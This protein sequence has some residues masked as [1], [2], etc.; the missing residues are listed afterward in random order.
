LKVFL[1]YSYNPENE[2]LAEDLLAV[3][4]EALGFTP[5]YAKKKQQ[6]SKP[7]G[8]RNKEL[9]GECQILVGLLTKDVHETKDGKDI[10]HPESDV[11]DEVSYADGRGLKVIVLVE[12]GTTIP[13]N[14]QTRCTYV[15]LIKGNE[16]KLLVDLTLRLK[17]EV[18]TILKSLRCKLDDATAYYFSVPGEKLLVR[19]RNAYF[20][21]SFADWLVEAGYV[22]TA[23]ALGQYAVWAKTHG[24]NVVSRDPTP[25]EMGLVVLPRT[26]WEKY[27][28]WLYEKDK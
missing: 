17:G 23:K 10:F 13:T 15:D 4:L 21:Y 26:L 27:L 1:S 11:I 18:S 3:F 12:S 14:I 19:G 7:P 28:F 20:M 16:S 2:H 6:S 24:F 8:I 5:V 22:K 9:I 25:K